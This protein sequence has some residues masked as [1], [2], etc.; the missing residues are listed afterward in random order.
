MTIIE[1]DGFILR[2][3]SLEDVQDYWDCMQDE[4][5]KKGFRS[6]P[7]TIGEAKTEI[8]EYIQKSCDGLMDVFTIVVD[9]KF[10]GNVRLDKQNWDADT[11][12]GRFHIWLH[13]D[14]RG[15]GLATKAA[16]ELLKY[17]FE[18]KGLKKIYAQCKKSNK[19]MCRVNEKIGF[20]R[21]EDRLVNGVEKVWWEI[22]S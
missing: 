13:P 12:E 8:E 2:P 11:D 20:K 6:V 7:E 4:E 15:R 21:V 9:G 1:S 5:T 19:A 3:L 22:S 14:F 18:Q 10:A 17:G 16:K